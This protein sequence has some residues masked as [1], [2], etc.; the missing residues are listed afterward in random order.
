MMKVRLSVLLETTLSLRI[1]PELIHFCWR[2]RSKPVDEPD[3]DLIMFPGDGSFTPYRSAT[4]GRVFL[5]RFNSSPAR[6][7]FWLQSKSQHAEGQGNYFSERD[8]KLGEIVNSILE[9]G[10]PDAAQAESVD[11]GSGGS[12]RPSDDQDEDME[13]AP[14]SG[15]GLDRTNSSTGGAG[16]D[17]TGGDVREE[18]HEAREGGADGGRA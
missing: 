17:A 16:A 18:G 15:N 13:D 1:V 8:L 6:H 14:P 11:A 5:L 9:T 3:P 10:D 2:P 7:L 12:R 4:N